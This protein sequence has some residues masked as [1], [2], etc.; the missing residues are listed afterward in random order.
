MIVADGGDDDVFSVPDVELRDPDDEPAGSAEPLVA[1]GVGSGVGEGSVPAGVVD[2]DDDAQ[3][4]VHEVDP[5][6]PIRVPDVD[7]TLEPA[8]ARRLQDVR[9]PCLQVALGRA[10]IRASGLQQVPHQP[11]AGAPLAGELLQHE[12]E[13]PPTDQPLRP[14]RVEGSFD[15]ERVNP[16]GAGEVEQGPLRGRHRQVVDPPDVLREQQT[17]FVHDGSRGLVGE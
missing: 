3:L 8:E 16:T 7:L 6:D 12:H 9:E 1:A 2:L 14:S 17:R 13:G 5:P 4:P 10:V 11:N 15:A